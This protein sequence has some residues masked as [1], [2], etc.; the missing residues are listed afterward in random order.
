MGRRKGGAKS[1]SKNK[2]TDKEEVTTANLPANLHMSAELMM[3]NKQ[4]YLNCI[5]E[6][7]HK[8][9]SLV[10]VDNAFNDLHQRQEAV[11]K[12]IALAPLKN[13]IV[14]DPNLQKFVNA[15]PDNHPLQWGYFCPKIN[16]SIGKYSI[17]PCSSILGPWRES[18]SIV[19]P[20]VCPSKVTVRT[21]AALISHLFQNGDQY[22]MAAYEY[23]KLLYSNWHFPPE[24]I[25][26]K[27]V[28]DENARSVQIIC[29]SSNSDVTG[30]EQGKFP[31]E[32]IVV[33]SVDDANS[34]P[35]QTLG[36]SGNSDV[37]GVEQGSN[38]VSIPNPGTSVIYS[39]NEDKSSDGTGVKQGS[40]S[41]VADLPGDGET[42][43]ISAR[44]G[45]LGI[46]IKSSPT[47]SGLLVGEIYAGSQ[48]EGTVEVGDIILK[49]NNVEIRNEADFQSFADKESR[50]FLMKRKLAI[51]KDVSPSQP[52]KLLFSVDSSTTYTDC[53]APEYRRKVTVPI[54]QRIFTVGEHRMAKIATNKYM[55]FVLKMSIPA[56]NEDSDSEESYPMFWREK[57]RDLHVLTELQS[58]FI[59]ALPYCYPLHYG[60]GSFGK[61]KLFCPCCQ[62]VRPWRETHKLD[63]ELAF[64]C[65]NN[66]M[67]PSSQPLL[68]HLHAY[69]G[70][71]KAPHKVWKSIGCFFHYAAFVYLRM[72]LKEDH[73]ADYP[74]MLRIYNDNEVVDDVI[75]KEK[76]ANAVPSR[77][78]A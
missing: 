26:S 78:Y 33:N 40:V 71:H 37:T 77:M 34:R 51:V 17:C 73:K 15:L 20:S 64:D 67:F 38:E 1:A 69:G 41:N 32:K 75:Q 48:L 14:N 58:N 4:L 54:P 42:Y 74:N 59:E 62:A 31:P 3:E 28:D 72:L 46:Q 65:K 21:V 8:S 44:P 56:D 10:T 53:L 29:P 57:K 25:V 60:F 61:S 35:V 24:D 30:V 11:K 23:L 68:D 19:L 22:H 49:I 13:Q 5:L 76:D 2:S 6:D 52:D 66:K 45:K 70:V 63:D 50:D 36:P 39:S 18:H 12:M 55:I 47:S 27:S 7:H 16:G 9:I 43:T